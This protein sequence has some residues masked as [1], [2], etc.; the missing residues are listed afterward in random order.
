MGIAQGF[1]A[2]NAGMHK[3]DANAARTDSGGQLAAVTTSPEAGVHKVERAVADAAADVCIHLASSRWL[4][5]S[6]HDA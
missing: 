5:G 3:A 1:A 6:V 4:D 2:G